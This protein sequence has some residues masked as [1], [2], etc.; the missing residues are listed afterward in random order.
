MQQADQECSPNRQA[1]RGLVLRD[2]FYLSGGDQLGVGM[3]RLSYVA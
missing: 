2:S 1:T 3:E